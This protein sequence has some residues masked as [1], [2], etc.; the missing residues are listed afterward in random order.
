MEEYSGEDKGYLNLTN[1]Q[2]LLKTIKG[3]TMNYDYLKS[4]SKDE[5]DLIMCSIEFEKI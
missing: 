4:L 2:L 3:I 1:R 5:L